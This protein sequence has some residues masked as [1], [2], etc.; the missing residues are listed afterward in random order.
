MGF[1][2]IDSRFMKFLGRFADI[3][4][5]GFWS[6]ICSIPIFTI[7]TS[8]TAAYYVTLKMVRDEECYIT[9]DFF[10]GFRANFRKTTLIWLVTMILAVI[11]YFDFQLMN[12]MEMKFE[13][14]FRVMTIVIITN[15][16]FLGG[17]IFP[18]SARF[19]NTIK[20]TVKNTVIMCIGNL[21]V[22]V[23]VFIINAAP[24]FLLHNF[25]D[26]FPLIL[27][28]SISG[29]CYVNSLL[30]RGIFDKYINPAKE[31][32]AGKGF[33]ESANESI[34]ESADKSAIEN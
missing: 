20:N 14:T 15:A 32:N 2:D 34:E 24:F 7:G 30:L 23:V 18:L 25:P 17:Y 10:K 26:A 11:F 6:V 19:E 28:F 21:G 22:S 5:L 9:R 3:M 4:I 16:F 29:V 33:E 13:S 31:K 8:I 27:L 1:L 12:A